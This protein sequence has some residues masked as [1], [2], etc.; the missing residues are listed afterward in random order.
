MF[1]FSF[2]LVSAPSISPFDVVALYDFQGRKPD[3]ELDFTAGET[4]RVTEKIND[5]WLRGEIGGQIGAFPCNFVDISVDIVNKL[6]H[7]EAKARNNESEESGT[8]HSERILY[9][10]GIFDY[11]SDVQGD[12]S[13]NAGD[14]IQVL[15]K[16]GDEWIEG[17]LN[18]RVGMF[19][20]AYVEMVTDAMEDQPGKCSMLLKWNLCSRE[21]TSL[22]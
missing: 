7:S 22:K 5:E 13:F 14:V 21:M 17:E 11:N 19:P 1:H 8:T 3:G 10:K 4:I 18:G 6:P 20:V 12:L 2:Q 15:K 16:V 9:C